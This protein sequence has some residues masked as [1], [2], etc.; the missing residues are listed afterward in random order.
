MIEA[1]VISETIVDNTN[2]VRLGD[3]G[4]HE[5]AEAEIGPLYRALRGEWGACAGY[6]YIDTLGG[7]TVPVGWIFRRTVAPRGGRAPAFV[8][9]VWVMVGQRDES[10]FVW[11]YDVKKRRGTLPQ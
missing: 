6:L 11:R 4:W 8:R 2:N 7:A 10:G 1:L 5:P 3:T 9:E